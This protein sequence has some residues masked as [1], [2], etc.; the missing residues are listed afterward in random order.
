MIREDVEDGAGRVQQ[1]FGFQ[2]SIAPRC[3]ESFAGGIR[4]KKQRVRRTAPKERPEHLDI[5]AERC[6]VVTFGYTTHRCVRR[7][8]HK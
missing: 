2:Y 4:S 6:R 3:P 5:S 1:A 8:I 7:L